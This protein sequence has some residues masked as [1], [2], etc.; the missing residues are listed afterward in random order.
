MN[1]MNTLTVGF[2]RFTAAACATM[3]TAAS[4]WAF[5]NSTA[6]PER[7]PFH[8][9]TVMA[10]NAQVRTAHVQARNTASICWNKSLSS[11]RPASSPIRECLRG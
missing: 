2:S 11:G 5:V 4:A 10:A 9:A 3:I 6:S 7:D 1:V 8:F